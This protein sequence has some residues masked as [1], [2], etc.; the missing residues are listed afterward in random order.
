[1]C[2]AT[3]SAEVARGG[4]SRVLRVKGSY[5]GCPPI[6]HN[7]CEVEGEGISWG[8]GVFWAPS[9]HPSQ[10]FMSVLCSSPGAPA[11]EGV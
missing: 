11:V 1:M 6:P 5:W 3:Q 7:G 4:G 9:L 2:G 10:S 8:R